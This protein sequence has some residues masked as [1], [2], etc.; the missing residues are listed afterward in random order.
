MQKKPLCSNPG[1]TFFHTIMIEDVDCIEAGEAFLTESGWEFP[2]WL[3]DL[4]LEVET[5]DSL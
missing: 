1:D 3:I 5:R 4:R 2:Q